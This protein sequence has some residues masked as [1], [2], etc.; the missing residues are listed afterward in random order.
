M[1]DKIIAFTKLQSPYCHFRVKVAKSFFSRFKGLM[2][3]QKNLA[4]DQALVITKCNSIHTFF[5]KFDID[6]VFVDE[7]Y[8]VVEIIE[9]LVGL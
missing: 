9:T 5:M 1:P 4:K 8:K 7:E 2:G 3:G 6:A